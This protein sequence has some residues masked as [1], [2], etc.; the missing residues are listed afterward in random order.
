MQYVPTKVSQKWTLPRVSF[1][2]WPVIF[3]NQKY[4]PAKIPNI[5]ATPI[6]MWKCPT[7]KYVACNMMSME[8]CAR[9]NPLTPP[10]TNIEIKPNANS[11]AELIRSFEPYK[12]PIHI[13]TT[14]VEGM[15]IISVG[16][17]NASEETGFMP[18]TNM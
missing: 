2:M 12:L 10:L 3:G 14:T 16:N 8:G 1:I 6:T 17:E 18:L 15:V 7:T 13:R 9:K 11:D 4:V 5:A